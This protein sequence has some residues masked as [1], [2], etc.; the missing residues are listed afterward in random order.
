MSGVFY[1]RSEFTEPWG[2]ALPPFEGCMI[3]HV[4]TAGQGWLEVE[5]M[6]PHLLRPGDLALVPHGQ[7]HRLVSAPGRRSKACLRSRA[8]R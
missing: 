1:C 5:G 2:L 3:F 6:A 7:G 8:R 4:V